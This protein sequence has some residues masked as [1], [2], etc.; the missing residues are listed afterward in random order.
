MRCLWHY[1]YPASGSK[2]WKRWYFWAT[3][4]RLEPIRKAAET[5]RRHID[6]I[7]TYDEHPVTNAR[8]E[9]L[10]RQIQNIKSMA[11]AEGSI[12]THAKAGIPRNRKGMMG[13]AQEADRCDVRGAR[14]LAHRRL[15]QANLIA[16][17]RAKDNEQLLARGKPASSPATV[18]T[19]F[20]VSGTTGRRTV[21][22]RSGAECARPDIHHRV[23]IRKWVA[24]FPDLWTAE[25]WLYVAT[26]GDLFSRRAVGWSIHATVTAQLITDALVMALVWRGKPDAVLHHTDRDSQYTRESFQR[27]LVDHGVIGSM[28]R[29]ANVWD[30]SAMKSFFSSLKTQRMGAKTYRTRAQAE[31]DVFDYIE[32]FD[33][34]K[35]RHSTLGYLNSMKF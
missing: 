9:G 2:F 28:S 34:P 14:G 6:N 18:P 4:S 11:A 27:L 3:H 12:C 20:G 13:E 16:S 31:A 26:V 15:C 23:N 17:A 35:R 21:D 32:C 33:N 10:N 7:L 29:A 24:D 22:A 25:G 5:I 30:N 1:V 8:S 19:A